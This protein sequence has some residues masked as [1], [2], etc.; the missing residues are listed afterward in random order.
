MPQKPFKRHGTKEPSK[1]QF[2]NRLDIKEI[3][4][5]AEPSKHGNY[6]RLCFPNRRQYKY[7]FQ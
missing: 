7:I 3:F 5:M 6:F 2:V 1:N 4:K